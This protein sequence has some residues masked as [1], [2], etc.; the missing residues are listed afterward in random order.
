[1][2]AFFVIALA[3]SLGGCAG[4]SNEK[5]AQLQS[6]ADRTCPKTPVARAQCLNSIEEREMPGAN[7]DDGRIIH[8]ARLDL[9]RKVE[10]GQITKEAGELEFARIVASMH[11]QERQQ[12]AAA[13]AD[14][15]QRLRNA[16][17][18]LQS[19]NPPMAA[20]APAVFCQPWLNG[21]RCQ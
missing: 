21:V 9:A 11:E 3:L 7:T 5:L 19:I 4:V 8:A 12:Q 17:Q 6:E 10:S 18:A 16:G 2:K 1:M 15:G 14:M 13:M 20:P